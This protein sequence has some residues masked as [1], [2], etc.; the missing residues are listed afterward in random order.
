MTTLLCTLIESILYFWFLF[1]AI[2]MFEVNDMM[3]LTKILRDESLPQEN[4]FYD[5]SLLC[6]LLSTKIRFECYQ[7]RF[8]FEKKPFFILEEF[9]NSIKKLLSD[10]NFIFVFFLLLLAGNIHFQQS[11]ATQSKLI[12]SLFHHGII[13]ELGTPALRPL[14]Q[15]SP[16]PAQQFEGMIKSVE[17]D[18]SKTIYDTS[19]EKSEPKTDNF[20]K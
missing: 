18:R 1:L 3:E 9:N 14:P 16:V 8:S 10:L 17:C 20:V 11:P 19:C 15:R 7:L 4:R 2:D 5:V 12:V 6:F 13:K